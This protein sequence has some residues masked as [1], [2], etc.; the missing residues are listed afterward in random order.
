[1][2]MVPLVVALLL[3]GPAMPPHPR[4]GTAGT[5]QL[6]PAQLKQLF[7]QARAIALAQAEV[8]SMTPQPACLLSAGPA[9]P[10][11]DA[12]IWL[13]PVPTEMQFSIRSIQP[14][15]CWRA[16]SGR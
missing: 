13:K 5:V 14:P 9:D 6:P 1:M 15:P 12:G 3:T 11:V 4:S 2:P 16:P 8:M 10:K 7:D